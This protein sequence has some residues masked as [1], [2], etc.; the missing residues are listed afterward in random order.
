MIYTIEKKFISLSGF[1]KLGWH[2][3]RGYVKKWMTVKRERWCV[4]KNNRV[5]AEC[6]GKQIAI[7][8]KNALNET[9][10]EIPNVVKIQFKLLK[11]WN[12]HKKGTIFETYG[13]LVE[14]LYSNNDFIEF[15]DLNYFESIVRKII[16]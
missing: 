6:R 16:Q 2:L 1:A 5:I 15:K 14:R 7:A 13:G 4:L 11:D 12:E 3:G 10:Q 9:H 8:I